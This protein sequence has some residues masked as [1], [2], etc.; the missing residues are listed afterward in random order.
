MDRDDDATFA[1]CLN[2]PD[3]KTPPRSCTQAQFNRADI[4][5]DADL[6][7]AEYGYGFAAFTSQRTRRR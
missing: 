7:L 3:V 2:G 6:D 1:A 4:Q 5:S